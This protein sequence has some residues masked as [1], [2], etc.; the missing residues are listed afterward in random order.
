MLK[1]N[2]KKIINEN[3]ASDLSMK[4]ERFMYMTIGRKLIVCMCLRE[5]EVNHFP[6][7]FFTSSTYNVKRFFSQL[8]TILFWQ[9]IFHSVPHLLSFSLINKRILYV[10]IVKGKN[11]KQQKKYVKMR[12]FICRMTTFISL[13]AHLKVIFYCLLEC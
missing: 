5:G 2:H 1:I 4:E 9:I 11:R 7:H 3:F 13:K 12:D 8:Y 6:F 10:C